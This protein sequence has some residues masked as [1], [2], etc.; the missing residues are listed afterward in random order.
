MRNDLIIAA[1]LVVPALFAP[2]VASP[3]HLT[4]LLNLWMMIALAQSWN[5]ISGMTGYVSFGHA[6]FFGI[7][8]Y[9]GAIAILAGW[10]W[11]LAV[12][13]GAVLAWIVALPLGVLTLR[14]RGPYFAIAML[15]LNELGRIIATLWVDMTEGG[16]GIALHPD[17]LPSLTANYTLMLILAIISCGMVAWIYNGRMG[18]EL[19]AIR[20]GEDVSEMLGVDTVRNKV[21]AFVLSAIVPGAAGVG[22]AMFTS[23]ID[24]ASVFA[25]VL[26]I[27]MIV[28]VLLGGSG[29]IWGPVLGAF[30]VTGLQ[31]V[32][33]AQFPMVHMMLMGTLLIV[34][35]LYLPNGILSIIHKRKRIRPDQ[36]TPTSEPAKSAGMQEVE[37]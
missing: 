22:Y 29:T 32:F 9:A 16:D 13:A 11:Y 8:S 33:W 5:L 36:I 1:L 12:V 25:P 18:L 3:Y 28:V 7:G 24:P 6:A 37:R 14:L 17:L 23:Y 27:Q 30:I 34:V 20:E 35:I 15:G 26:N 19:R 2:M 31:E 21:I 4:F 10:P